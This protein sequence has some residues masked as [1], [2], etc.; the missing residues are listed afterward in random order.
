M[1]KGAFPKSSRAS[2]LVSPGTTYHIALD[3]YRKGPDDEPETGGY[4]L[5]W[6]RSLEDGA[7]VDSGASVVT[8]TEGETFTA[9]GSFVDPAHSSWTASADY[10]DGSPIEPLPIGP[11]NT[12]ELRHRYPDSAVYV[13]RVLVIADADGAA[14]SDVVEMTVN[15]VRPRRAERSSCR[16]RR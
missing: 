1:G 16:S 2:F 11:G 15:G 14:G 8:A 7:H 4:V 12:F 6:R 9:S 13:I 3:G 5:T 10:G